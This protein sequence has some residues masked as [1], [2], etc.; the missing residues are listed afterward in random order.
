MSII[1]Q[2]EKYDVQL[3]HVQTEKALNAIQ[4]EVHKLNALAEYTNDKYIKKS[5][6][7]TKELTQ[8]LHQQVMSFLGG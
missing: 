5:E 6:A 4:S 8:H 3:C 1:E 2:K 7:H